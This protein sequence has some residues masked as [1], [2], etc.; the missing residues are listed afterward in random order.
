MLLERFSDKA[1]CQVSDKCDNPTHA[2]ALGLE[3][4]K[5]G[6]GELSFIGGHAGVLASARLLQ[7]GER[8]GQIECDPLILA[9]AG[10][11]NVGAPPSGNGLSGHREA[12]QRKARPA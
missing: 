3:V 4:C 10:M 6:S 11:S 5:S 1:S 2:S 12:S 9:R 7:E 8:S